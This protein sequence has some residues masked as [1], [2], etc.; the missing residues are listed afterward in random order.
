MHYPLI[1][2][3]SVII[4]LLNLTVFPLLSQEHT[5]YF[6]TLVFVETPLSYLE[7]SVPISFQEAMNRNHY[8]FVY[9]V[10]NRLRSIRFYN[11]E[12]PKNLNHTTNHFMRSSW[13]KFDYGSSQESITF[14]DRFG[15]PVE[16]LGGC[17]RFVYE[18]DSLGR[19]QKLYFENMAGERI[20]VSWNIYEYQWIRETTGALIEERYNQAGKIMP[21]RPYF[22]FFRTRFFFDYQ[23]RIRL[24]QN[25]DKEGRLIENESGAAQDLLTLN[26]AGNLIS[27]QVLDKA[28][29]PEKGNSPNVA[30]GIQTINEYGFETGL[31]NWDE[32]Q[33][34][35]YNTYGICQSKTSFDQWGNLK[36]RRFFDPQGKPAGH[37]IAGYH[38]LKLYW[39]Q[40]GNQRKKLEYYD[41]QGQLTLHKTRGYAL[42]RHNYDQ[43]GNLIK[44]AY[45]N[46]EG[47]LV[48]RKDNGIAY[49]NFNYNKDGK[50]ISRQ[51]FD[52]DGKLI[53]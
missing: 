29:N 35:I 8:R 46:R 39:D 10:Q 30:Q 47:Q 41:T 22:K 4:F 25:V 28:G 34:P 6:S 33:K 16:V 9:D 21:I 50:Q 7:G 37:L 17:H 38:Q 11:G 18:L 15:R 49:L 45:Y 14:Y 40:S 13:L 44:I 48:N 32:N 20:E 27:W 26:K 1:K 31:L 3:F 2:H 36:E 12:Q 51:G 23:G 19:R 52:R 43:K 24:M 5:A 42:V 53:Q